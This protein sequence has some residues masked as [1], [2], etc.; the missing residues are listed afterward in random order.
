M[1]ARHGGA[2]VSS[3]TKIINVAIWYYCTASLYYAHMFV[4]EKLLWHVI[5][6]LNSYFFKDALQNV[7]QL[8]STRLLQMTK[9]YLMRECYN[10]HSWISLSS[11]LVFSHQH[12]IYGFKFPKKVFWRSL[13]EISLLHLFANQRPDYQPNLQNWCPSPLHSHGSMPCKQSDILTQPESRIWL[14]E[15]KYPLYSQSYI[16][17]HSVSHLAASICPDLFGIYLQPN[18]LWWPRLL[19]ET[20][21]GKALQLEDHLTQ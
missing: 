21:K 9:Y 13:P 7:Q 17:G 8:F 15:E 20:W 19:E 5:S 14:E 6:R 12:G 3:A 10:I 4:R 18:Q 11:D 1:Q 2:T 16:Q